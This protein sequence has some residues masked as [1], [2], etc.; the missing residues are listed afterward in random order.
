MPKGYPDS[1][2]KCQINGC[3]RTAAS[4]G[5][6][7]NHYV[8]LFIRFRPHDRPLENTVTAGLMNEVLDGIDPKSVSPVDK[9][10]LALVMDGLERAGLRFRERVVLKARFGIGEKEKTLLEIGKQ[11]KVT[12]E[13]VNQIEARALK[14]LRRWVNLQLKLAGYEGLK[15]MD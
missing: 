7:Q 2:S 15:C 10:D 11:F 13:R 14:R 9:D 12:R 8:I 3:D 4:F 6:C 5:F 1:Y